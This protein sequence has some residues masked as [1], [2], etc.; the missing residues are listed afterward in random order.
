[1]RSLAFV[2]SLLALLALTSCEEGGPSHQA[3][4]ISQEDDAIVNGQLDTTHTAVVAV[5]GNNFECSG[6][7]VQVKSGVG[8]VLTAAHCCTPSM[9]PEVVVVGNDYQSG[10]QHAVVGGSVLAN[11]CYQSFPG[12]TDDVCM[13]KFSNAAGLPVIPAM[14]PA[15]DNLAVGTD[16]TYV[17]YGLTAAPPGGGNSKR[18]SVAKKIGQLDTY[19]VEYDSPGQSGT[20]EGDSG[21]PALALVSGQEVVAAV[22]SYGDQACQQLGASIRASAVYDTF[23]APYLADQAPTP[24]C[25][26]KAD[27]QTCFNTSTDQA[28]PCG[29]SVATCLADAKCAA[30]VQC[31]QTCG[32][33]GS[34]NTTC[35]KNNLAGLP[36]Y[37]AIE[38]CVCNSACSTACGANGLCTWPK[39]GLK[40][41][42][43]TCASC[44]ESNCCEAAF[45]CQEDA[46]CHKCFG[47]NPPAACATNAAAA[48]YYACGSSNCAS[49]A[50]AN[51]AS[52]GAGGAGGSGA[53]SSSSSSTSSSG[54]TG[55]AG[56][57]SSGTTSSG[58]P[59]V[60]PQSGAGSPV[61]TGGCSITGE[62]RSPELPSS[63]LAALLFGGL[64]ALVRQR[65]RGDGAA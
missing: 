5:L 12:S 64:A 25:G 63:P 54:S 59:S 24:V 18:R 13:L 35:S 22:T 47:A 41:A 53:M 34:C 2:S 60:E 56:G 10:Q 7:I 51:P 37:V 40:I 11:S 38:Q 43:T 17:G 46:T 1:M 65:R 36:K 3:E 44:V 29:K 26:W 19:F 27:C 55:G 16:V 23:I 48:A 9:V 28:G 21:G 20:C 45:A 31:Y 61:E 30:L 4:R 8:Y 32:G 33:V 50:L 42:D 62:R 15:E 52:I 6:T 39:C 58:A 57:A 14:T 49:C